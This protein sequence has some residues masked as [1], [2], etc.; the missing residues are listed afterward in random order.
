MNDSVIPLWLL[1]LLS[2]FAALTMI[3]GRLGRALF[4]LAGDPPEDPVSLQHWQRRRKWLAY[5]ELSALPAFG[6][7]GVAATVHFNLPPVASVGIS[8]VLGAVG[9]GMVLDAAVFLFRKRVGVPVNG[10]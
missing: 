1:W 8:M 10:D 2:T 3:A 6:T 7:I 9:F 5:S 4:G